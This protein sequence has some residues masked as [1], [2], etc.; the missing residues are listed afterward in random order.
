LKMKSKRGEK[1]VSVRKR[2]GKMKRPRGGDWVMVKKQKIE[3][4][5]MWGNILIKE[6]CLG[7]VSNG[8]KTKEREIGDISH[9]R[10]KTYYWLG[11]GKGG[12]RSQ[13]RKIVGNQKKTAKKSKGRENNRENQ[14]SKKGKKE[15]NFFP[16]LPG[17]NQE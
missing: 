3:N 2:N 11:V 5:V 14:N 16:S 12:K 17:W 6:L 7:G 9:Y 4:H 10:K 1:V 15:G 13:R 8:N